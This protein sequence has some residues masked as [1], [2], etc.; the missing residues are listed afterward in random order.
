MIIL[1]VG[2]GSG[3]HVTPALAVLDEIYRQNPTLKAY[4]LT[5]RK[6]Y[7]QAKSI[8]SKSPLKISCKKIFAGKFR[9]YH[10]VSWFRQLIDIPTV[11]RNMGDL[12]LVAVGFIE[13]IVLLLRIRPNVVFAKGGYVCLPVGLAAK[14]L[15]I[16]IVVHDSDA[17]PGLTSRVLAKFAKAIGT[18]APVENYPYPKELTHYVGVPVGVFNGPTTAVERERFKKSLGI[19]N[20][21]K[22]LLLVY[23]GGLGSRNIN[24]AVVEIAEK[25]LEKVSIVHLTGQINFEETVEKAIDHPDYIIKTFLPGITSIMAVADIVLSRAGA[26][27]LAEQAM[28]SKASIIIPSPY[29]TGGHQLKN[30]KVLQQAKAALVLE[31]DSIILNPNR[32]LKVVLGLVEHPEVRRDLGRKMHGLSKA[33]AAVD[34]AALIVEAAATKSVKMT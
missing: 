20:P 1:A 22:P 19:K 34:M 30:A 28:L 17:H 18:G 2:G 29:L 11:L 6:F 4:F 10:Q 9:R 33:D 8:L 26:T 3:G 23:G 5:D 25:L 12:L 31:E 15:G 32:L 27:S 21:N 24:L 7:P 13:S 16:P 14:V